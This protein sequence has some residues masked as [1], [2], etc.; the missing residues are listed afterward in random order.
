MVAGSFAGPWRGEL[1]AGRAHVVATG[2][3]EGDMAAAAP[4]SAQRRHAV[5]GRPWVAINQVH[6]ASVRV[7]GPADDPADAV[8]AD[9]AVTDRDDVALA[10]LTADCAPIA[11]ASPEGVIGVAHAGWRGLLAGVVGATVDAMVALGA[12]SIDAVV[13]PCI[14][15]GCY[16][17]SST[18]LAA[19]V[20]AFGPEIA[21]RDRQGHPAF[22]LSAGV[23]AA[24]G[25]A[26]VARV[27]AVP[28]CTAHDAGWW[29]W[30][31]RA[32]RAR[33]ATVVFT[34]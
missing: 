33:Q 4:G 25:R 13:G 21:G 22:D 12:T 17:F 27:D 10:V 3:G 11:L 15:V 8:D 29:S 6:G 34:A 9:A 14:C 32:D 7:V 30:R 28:G 5:A 18:D 31:A 23:V 1:G 24:L 26:G 16:E 20:E 2:I 19:A